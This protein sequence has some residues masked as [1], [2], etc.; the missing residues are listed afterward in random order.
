MR[1]RKAYSLYRTVLFV[2]L[3]PTVIYGVFAR[4][5]P[6]VTLVFVPICGVLAVG[7][8]HRFKSS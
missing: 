3:I 1:F 7:S 8:Y 4:G 5:V 2:V 6:K